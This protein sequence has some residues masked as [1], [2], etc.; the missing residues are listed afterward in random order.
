M[1]ESRIACIQPGK[2]QGCLS[3]GLACWEPCFL[4]VLLTQMR[5]CL[6][7]PAICEDGCAAWLAALQHTCLREAGLCL[8]SC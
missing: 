6:D 4:Q 3:V 2:L 8:E 1:V 5:I 7:W